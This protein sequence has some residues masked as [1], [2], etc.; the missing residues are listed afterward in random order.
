MQRL[1]YLLTILFSAVLSPNAEAANMSIAL[2]HSVERRG[3]SN[4]PKD[5]WL[6]SLEERGADSAFDLLV[7]NQYYS[8]AQRAWF[9]SVIDDILFGVI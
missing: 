4:V 2:R 6:A 9:R 3:D 8:Q 7:N 5:V 1:I